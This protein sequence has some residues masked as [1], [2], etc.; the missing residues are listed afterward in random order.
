[1]LKKPAADERE[2]IERAID[3][4]LDVLPLCL[5]GD[6]QGAMLKLHTKEKA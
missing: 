6:L 3:K 5:A 2:A 1:V 4:S